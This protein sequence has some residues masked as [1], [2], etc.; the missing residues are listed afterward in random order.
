MWSKRTK[1]WY[2][3]GLIFIG[4]VV[5]I[6]F[7]SEMK[8]TPRGLA[9]KHT[10]AAAPVI[11]ASEEIPQAVLNL[12]DT[13]KAF[14]AVSKAV[15]PTV[16]SIS[17][18]K[19]V[20]RSSRDDDF[21]GPLFRDFFGRELP[22][23]PEN[24][25]LQGLGSG[26]I[27]S[28]DGYI[29]TNNHVIENADDIQVGLYDNRTFQ[30]KLIGSDPLT[31][32][33]VIQIKGEKLPVAR[34]GDSDALDV[35]EWVLAVGNP[36]G[37][38]ST[39]T[40]GIVSAKGRS[41]GI[42]QDMSES[43]SRSGSYAIENFIQT[44]AAINP[45]NSGGA[46]VNLNGEVVGIN[47]AIATNTGF[48]QGYGFAVPIN[49]AK[50]IMNDLIGKGYV[51][52]AWLGIGMR[53]VDQKVA[54]YYKMEK[55]QGVLIDQV[56]DDSPAHKAGLKTLD[57]ILELD[58]KPMNQSNEV[59]NTVA[60]KNPGDVISLKV[61]RDDGEKI[62]RVKLGQRDTGKQ[63]EVREAE[64]EELPKLGLQVGELTKEIRSQIDDYADEKGVVVTQVEAAGAAYNA[65]IRQYDLIKEI[66]KVKIESVSDYRSA[67][68]KVKKGDVVLFLI[69]KRD[70]EFHAFVEMP[71]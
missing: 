10:P 42:I 47:T 49:L 27:V 23:M 7:A 33:A 20:K 48:N 19:V 21:F 36:L 37:L 64:N 62:I 14:T 30:A 60:L 6:I 3:A 54:K 69:L 39:V 63:P 9:S 70:T 13:G 46:M 44:D 55:P 38:N 25:V 28:A 4:V 53:P 52:R 58:G 2:A 31:E 41:I 17:T 59:Q 22:S 16:V 56:M 61:L 1:R 32:V 35:G 43:S 50:K 8:W 24:Q 34:L 11:G 12:Q 45:G 40:A 67:L 51:T 68:R 65:G 18:S 66:G 71:E 15:L 5:G 57:I 29:L 26:V